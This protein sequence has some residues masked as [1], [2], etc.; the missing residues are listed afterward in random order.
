MAKTEKFKG[1]RTVGFSKTSASGMDNHNFLK[2]ASRKCASKII[3]FIFG[4]SE[5][6]PRIVA[7]GGGDLEIGGWFPFVDPP[8]TT[9][10]SMWIPPVFQE[11]IFSLISPKSI[12]VSSLDLECNRIYDAQKRFNSKVTTL[13]NKHLLL[14]EKFMKPIYGTFDNFD[15]DVLDVLE[16]DESK[17]KF[18]YITLWNMDVEN[19]LIGTNAWLD[20][21]APGGVLV[22]QN[23]S[24]ANFLYVDKTNASGIWEFHEDIKY[25]DDCYMYHVPLYYG[26]TI[27]KKKPDQ[28]TDWDSYYKSDYSGSTV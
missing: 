25:R 23:V 26:F 19:H 11:M 1:D 10:T 8:E 27:I 2:D 15:Y 18:D 4:E 6:D 21:L 5:A 17:N 12:L 20:M 13:N 7:T 3:H 28:N 24:D 16:L 14:F 9:E 22:L